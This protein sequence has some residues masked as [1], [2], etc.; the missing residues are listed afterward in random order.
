METIKLSEQ[1]IIN[2][3]CSLISEQEQVHISEI[4]VELMYEDDEGYSAEAE[5]STRTIFLTEARMIE[6]IRAWL[7]TQ[8]AI[9]PFSTSL[10]L[11]LDDEEGIIAYAK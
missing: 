11:E 6:A 3:I 8:Y 1:E 10:Q 7:Q 9:D 2:S 5:I 4:A